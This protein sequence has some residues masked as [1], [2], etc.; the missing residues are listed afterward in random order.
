MENVK[1]EFR[2]Y[3]RQ[4]NFA[5]DHSPPNP[6]AIFLGTNLLVNLIAFLG[7]QFFKLESIPA[8][9]TYVDW[10]PKT[11]QKIREAGV[12]F[13][14][15]RIE[16]VTALAASIGALTL[17]YRYSE[18]STQFLW[19]KADQISKFF[20]KTLGESEEALRFPL[21]PP[22]T[23]GLLSTMTGLLTPVALGSYDLIHKYFLNNDRI[24]ET[25][26]IFNQKIQSELDDILNTMISNKE[27]KD[28]LQNIL[29]YGPPGTGK[30][31]I[32]KWLAKHS[33]MNYAI[34]SGGDLLKSTNT[35]SSGQNQSSTS[36]AVQTL[37]I[38]IQHAKNQ[39]S[40]TVVFIDEAEAFLMNRDHSKSQE[41]TSL[42]NTFLELTGQPTSKMMLILATNRPTD[43]DAAVRSRLDY[44]LEIPPPEKLQRE[45]II[46]MDIPLLISSPEIQTLFTQELIQYIAEKTEGFSGRD[47]LKVVNRL[48]I[49][50]RKQGI[51]SE[52]N[53]D[54]VIQKLVEQEYKIANQTTSAHSLKKN[55][56]YAQIAAKTTAAQAG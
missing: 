45:Q 34:L 20:L 27:N 4:S 41:L 13:W 1:E 31:M 16:G 56:L 23:I 7:K 11:C 40:P 29:F 25:K 21:S 39:T 44:T 33:G 8:K 50:A 6:F 30:T 47:L 37:Q 53:V 51:L 5:P 3:N 28:P 10:W 48:K 49:D 15:R 35:Q 17:T 32:S 14:S 54:Q 42:L 12:S 46:T 26:P 22:I 38:L 52:V 18:G 19:S 2:Y 43:L 55:P 24:T 36:A 9:F